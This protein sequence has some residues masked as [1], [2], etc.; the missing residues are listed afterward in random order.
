MLASVAAT[1]RT[2]RAGGSPF[3]DGAMARSG[4]TVTEAG[5][6]DYSGMGRE[7]HRPSGNT[8]RL[9]APFAISGTADG[10]AAIAGPVGSPP[11]G[12]GADLRRCDQTGWSNLLV[13]R[14]VVA[15]D[16]LVTADE[17]AARRTG[18]VDPP[19]RFTRP[20]V[21]VRHRSPVT[22]EHDDVL[23]ELEESH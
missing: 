19:T 4:K 2:K 18:Q 16:T 21:G 8:D 6:M 15:R 12:P 17:P 1:R 23:A 5:V 3:V 13:A 10:A 20:R 11:A 14:R 22:G 9:P 7:D